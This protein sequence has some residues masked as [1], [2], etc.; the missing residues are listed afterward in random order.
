MDPSFLPRSTCSSSYQADNSFPFA[1]MQVLESA[2]STAAAVWSLV[3]AS[4]ASSTQI[5]LEPS[6]SCHGCFRQLTAIQSIA[7][8][9]CWCY[10]SVIAIAC[11]EFASSEAGLLEWSHSGSSCW[12]PG[13]QLAALLVVDIADDCMRPGLSMNAIS[14]GQTQTSSSSCSSLD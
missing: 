7:M 6:C 12:H 5:A 11:L 10:L 4:A 1:I 9:G 14:E 3:D 8:S 2:S 13:Q